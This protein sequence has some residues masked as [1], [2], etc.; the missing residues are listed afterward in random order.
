MIQGKTS[1]TFIEAVARTAR[2]YR[3][4]FGLATQRLVDYYRPESPGATVAFETADWKFI[5]RQSGEATTAIKEHAALKEFVRAG[6]RENIIRSLQ[7]AKGGYSEV[8]IFHE[9]VNGVVGR[10]FC[11]P[12]ASLLYSTKPDDFSA[13]THFKNKGLATKEALEAVLAQRELAER[14]R[15]AA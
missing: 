13:I 7:S 4:S 15:E 6:F 9:D 2:K 5:L 12:F 1:G 3:G 14:Q 10:F 11:D 8:G